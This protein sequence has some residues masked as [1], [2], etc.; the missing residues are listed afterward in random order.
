MH[1]IGNDFVVV[2]G[3]FVPAQI[4]AL[5]DRHTGIGFDQFII[6]SSDATADAAMRIFNP[7]GTE[8]GAC[9]NATRCVA[10]LLTARTGRSTLAIRTQAG[11][12]AC[13]THSDGQ[14]TV[15]M[16][17]PGL[18]WHDIPLASPQDTL[19]LDL[20]GDPAAISMGNPH[21]TVFVTDIAMADPEKDGPALEHHSL[22]PDRANIGFAQI[23]APGRIRL[24]VWERGA[25]L[26]RAC[27]SGACAALVNAHRRGL[28]GRT[29][30]L[31]LDGGE[32]QIAWREADG[33]VLMTGPAM[34][35]FHGEVHLSSYP[36]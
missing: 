1:G 30:T 8:A 9:G 22:F 14:V 5:S 35:A 10:S 4:R 19:H 31:V 28:A 27:G 3:H 7:D 21:A 13:E 17:P 24:R 16:G 36:A 32:L 29:A 20:P 26:T 34:T 6:L 18:A 11:L 15:D 33:H 23:L 25:G 12:L 2:E